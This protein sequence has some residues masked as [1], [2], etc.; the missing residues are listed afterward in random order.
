MTTAHPQPTPSSPLSALA[1]RWWL[2]LAIPLALAV[3]GYMLGAAKAPIYT[4]EA[5]TTVGSGNISAGAITGFPQA[6]QQM[7]AN[8]ARWVNDRGVEGKGDIPAGTEVTASPIPDSNVIRIEA[9]SPDKEAAVQS[10]QKAA[11]DLAEAVNSKKG[12]SDP[13][14]TLQQLN[15]VASDWG[16]AKA[17]SE[18]ANTTAQRA[19]GADR[20]AATVAAA[21]QRAAQ[22]A[23]RT[24]VLQAQMDALSEK[25]RQQISQGSQAANLIVVKPAELA[26]STKASNQQRYALGGLVLGLGLAL[27]LAV[28]LDRRNAR[29]GRRAEAAVVGRHGQGGQHEVD[30]LRDHGATRGDE[31]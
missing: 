5:R 16:Q 13:A 12:E 21:Q 26:E 24:A 19:I 29:S 28:L 31:A 7:A 15:K 14:V 30:V 18:A 10:A 11:D 20:P 3:V 1:E 2:A 4:A 8:Y 27:L 6:T 9:K 25:Y 17:A 23:S 22:T